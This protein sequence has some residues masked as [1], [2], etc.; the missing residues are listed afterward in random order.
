M[1][2]TR[3]VV[4]DLDGTITRHDTLLPY[5]FS[6]LRR[7]PWQL[8]R[9]LR[10]T[11]ALA[12]FAVGRA[13]HGALKSSL[14]KATLRGRSRAEIERSTARF[15]PALLARGVRADALRAI[16]AH[17]ARGDVL[18]LLSASP[19]LYVPEIAAQL[20]FAE[21]VCTGVAWGAGRLDGS[22]TTANRRGGEKTRCLDA[23]KLRYPGLR[24]AAYANATSDLDHLA[25]VDEPLLVCGSPHARKQAA[26]LRIPS[27]RWR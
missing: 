27:A 9:L 16:E 4:F 13:D 14:I 20:G 25:R 5:V 11:P 1:N 7:A 19:D 17:R 15:V 3:L 21:A 8:L 24:T 12:A 2:E 18:I 10:V 26:R 22:L 23:L 6:V